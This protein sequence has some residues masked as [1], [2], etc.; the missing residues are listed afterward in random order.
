M[1]EFGFQTRLHPTSPRPWRLGCDRFHLQI[2]TKSSFSFVNFDLYC[3]ANCGYCLTRMRPNHQRTWRRKGALFAFW[4]RLAGYT[5]PT[6]CKESITFRCCILNR[7]STGSDTWRNGFSGSFAV[8]TVRFCSPRCR[9]IHRGGQKGKSIL[10][11]CSVSPVCRRFVY[12]V[13][14][15]LQLMPLA[16]N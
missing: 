5:K 3:R 10:I 11:C 6:T 1:R 13:F 14:F 4:I 12:S 7:P 16:P 8:V 2:A 15:A 9:R